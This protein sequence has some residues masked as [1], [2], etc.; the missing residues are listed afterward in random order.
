ME[1]LS[2]LDDEDFILLAELAYEN[3]VDP[4]EFTKQL[5]N[6]RLDDYRDEIR[7]A[8]VQ[9]QADLAAAVAEKI[10]EEEAN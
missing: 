5:I 10:V 3:K 9:E 4:W 8:Q 6:Q 7:C 2:F 1:M